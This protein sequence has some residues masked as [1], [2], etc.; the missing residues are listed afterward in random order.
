MNRPTKIA[1]FVAAILFAWNAAAFCASAS[2]HRSLF[3]QTPVQSIL[4]N[5]H[6]Q[7]EPLAYPDN[8]QTKP[9]I[10]QIDSLTDVELG[11]LHMDL[12]GILFVRVPQYG[13]KAGIGADTENIALLLQRKKIIYPFHSFL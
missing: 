9:G 7:G 3:L 5:A 11:D 10:L 4:S 12:F 1:L 8:R 6:S 2:E 13:N